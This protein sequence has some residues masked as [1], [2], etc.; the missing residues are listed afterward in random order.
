MFTAGGPGSCTGEGHRTRVPTGSPH[1]IRTRSM[2][3]KYLLFFFVAFG[4]K[5]VLA[6]VTIYYIFPA[7]RSCPECDGDTLPIRMSLP[8]RVVARLLLRRVER[9]WCPHCRWEGMT[10]TGMQRELAPAFAL[11][12][13]TGA[14]R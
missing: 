6:L 5:A 10:R 11:D 8:G 3:A 13:E 1:P 9:R 14:P 12:P 7:E 2:W 4:A